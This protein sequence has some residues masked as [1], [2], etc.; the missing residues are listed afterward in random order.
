MAGKQPFRPHVRL[1]RAQWTVLGILL[2]TL[3]LEFVF[4]PYWHPWINDHL[5]TDTD[6]GHKIYVDNQGFLVV[7][8]ILFGTLVILMLTGV[9]PKAGYAIAGL[10]LLSVALARVS[11]ITRWLDQTTATLRG[12]SGAGMGQD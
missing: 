7:G 8:F 3:L 6:K 10:L 9:M 1:N 2:L 11:G 5:G 12:A 4:S